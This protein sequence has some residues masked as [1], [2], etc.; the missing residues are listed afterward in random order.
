MATERLHLHV[1]RLGAAFVHVSQ[2]FRQKVDVVKN[3][4]IERVEFHRFEVA[5]VEQRRSV[6]LSGAV[7]IDDE[8]G[9][10]ELLLLQ[11]GMDV[12]EEHFQVLLAIAVADDQGETL[13]GPACG[14]YGMSAWIQVNDVVLLDRLIGEQ[15]LTGGH[16][17]D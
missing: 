9:V 13:F 12:V 5:D 16:F 14:R 7:L 8:D 4:A 2:I 3:E 11:K 1:S 15:R 10:V 17:V 6:E